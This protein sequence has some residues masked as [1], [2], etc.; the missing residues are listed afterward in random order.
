VRGDLLGDSNLDF[1]GRSALIALGINRDL[2]KT[3]EREEPP[4]QAV[5]AEA[6][7][8]RAAV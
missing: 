1:I 4:L 5:E 3:I 8:G 2:V 7:A 6:A